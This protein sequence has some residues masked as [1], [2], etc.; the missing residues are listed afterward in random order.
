M[1]KVYLII[2]FAIVGLQ[3]S[4]FAQNAPDWVQPAPWIIGSGG[5]VNIVPGSVTNPVTT[6]SSYTGIYPEDLEFNYTRTWHPLIRTTNEAGIDE[7]S[8]PLYFPMSTQY[9]NGFGKPI[10]TINRYDNTADSSSIIFYDNRPIAA[11]YSFLPY[12]VAGDARFHADPFTDQSNFYA[13][14]FPQDA[15]T[16]ASETFCH[17]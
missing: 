3:Y 8:D 13:A 5:V 10:E 12:A 16:A 6:M 15:G 17:T 9:I 1:R 4:S 11:Q 7:S 14:R 2:S